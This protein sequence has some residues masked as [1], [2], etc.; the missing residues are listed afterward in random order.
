MPE[1]FLPVLLLDCLH[2]DPLLVEH[3]K[4]VLVL[5]RDHLFDPRFFDL[6]LKSL[7]ESWHDCGT[8]CQHNVIVKVD[9]KITVT[10]VNRFAGHFVDTCHFSTIHL[11]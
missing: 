10:L 11:R 8:S 1:P 3:D 2:P 5:A 9:S 4:V 7:L 6:V